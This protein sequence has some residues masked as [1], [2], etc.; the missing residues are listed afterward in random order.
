MNH[1][2]ANKKCGLDLSNSIEYFKC[3]GC[4]QVFYCDKACQKCDWDDEHEK[5]CEEMTFDKPFSST[6]KKIR[7]LTNWETA[8]KKFY[9]SLFK[10]ADQQVILNGI[11]LKN[12]TYVYL[13]VLKNV[14][15]IAMKIKESIQ[16][17][18]KML[19]FE[20]IQGVAVQ[21]ED[22]FRIFAADIMD[23]IKLIITTTNTEVLGKTPML[24]K[25]SYQNIPKVITTFSDLTENVIYDFWDREPYGNTPSIPSLYDGIQI[26]T[27]ER[28]RN[29]KMNLKLKNEV[30]N[31]A[32]KL[33]KELDIAFKK[34]KESL[35]R[36]DK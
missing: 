20:K 30:L 18:G 11:N 16:R 33:G 23:Y 36:G 22:T 5:E 35:K 7:G 2:C 29:Q 21:T 28:V 34:R 17:F 26:Y 8:L 1:F 32:A 19:N 24:S 13:D 3:V 10:Y 15:N 12:N 6:I 31:N 27:L 14:G 9:E 4:E 25:E